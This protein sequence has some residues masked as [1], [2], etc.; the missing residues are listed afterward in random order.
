MRKSL[1][2]ICLLSSLTAAT[3]AADGNPS[4]PDGTWIIDATA[5]ER[6]VEKVPPAKDAE[7]LA[8]MLMVFSGY[9]S[10]YTYEFKGNTATLSAYRGSK[11]FEY[12]RIATQGAESKYSQRNSPDSQVKTISVSVL[13]NENIRIVSSDMP[14]MSHLIW[15]RGQ[16]KTESAAPED[17][18]AASKAW[19]ESSQR[20]VNMLKNL[21]RPSVTNDAAQ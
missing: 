19:I 13:S 5:T 14:E 9:L 8:K 11:T 21:S 10:L 6:S 1:F 2:I 18:M 7:N 15:K 20:I 17:V 12:L 16:F 3:R 4:A